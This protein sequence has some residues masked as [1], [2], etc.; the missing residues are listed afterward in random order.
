MPGNVSLSDRRRRDQRKL[1]IDRGRGVI[2]VFDFR[3]GQGRLVRR[4]P[5][6]RLQSFIDASP[7]D[8]FAEL[9]NDRRL[10]AQDS[11]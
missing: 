7:L 4:A 11:S 6:H 3:L 2:F 10:I 5:E 8:E 9:T 1:H